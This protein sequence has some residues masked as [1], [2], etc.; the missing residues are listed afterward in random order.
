MAL[1]TLDLEPFSITAGVDFSFFGQLLHKDTR[2]GICFNPL[3][4]NQQLCGKK[5]DPAGM[6]FGTDC[7]TFPQLSGGHAEKTTTSVKDS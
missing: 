4:S 6:I 7:W 3:C 5:A 2:T 1:D